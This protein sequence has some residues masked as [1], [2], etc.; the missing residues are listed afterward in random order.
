MG[1]FRR[2]WAEADPWREGPWLLLGV[3]AL[4]APFA[5][6]GQGGDAHTAMLA[7]IACLAS[8]CL[9]IEAMQGLARLALLVVD[10]R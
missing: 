6:L 3:A 10:R 7:G 8:P 5:V 9:A 2:T 1:L 4:S